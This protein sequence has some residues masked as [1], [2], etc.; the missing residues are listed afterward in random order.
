M[1]IVRK[2]GGILMEGITAI[3]EAQRLTIFLL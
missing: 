3:T 1:I 2:L